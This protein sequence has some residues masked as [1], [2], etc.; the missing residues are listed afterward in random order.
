M[1]TFRAGLLLWAALAC[2]G[3]ESL[4]AALARYE[5]KRLEMAM[6]FRLVLHA[7]D[8]TTAE[9]AA[10]AAF[11]R[12]QQLNDIMSDY[13]PDSELSK[14][15]H[16]SGQGQAV[17]VSDDLWFVLERA[18]A[19]AERS[20]GAFDVTVGP[21]VNLWRR[22]R[23]QHKLPDPAR[24]ARAG[25]AVGYKHV[26]LDPERHTVELLAPN[27][28]LDLGGIAKGYAV[29]QA[30]K[31]LREQGIRQALIEAGGD[32]GVS[33]PPPG[34]TGWR[35]EL[36]S[37]DDTNAP[38]ARFL[39]LKNCAISTSG[40]LYQRLEING[41]RYSHIVDPHTGIG[42]TDHSVVNVIAP[43]GI[44]SD[45]LTKVV[46]VLGPKKGLEFIERTPGVVARTMRDIGGRIEVSESRGFA[47]YYERN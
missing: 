37:V 27:M 2:L 40:D 31:A 38:P 41:K 35:I 26:R 7:A 32:M 16:S 23:R 25:E 28:R 44:I 15:S 24:L 21:Y 8:Q 34:K 43:Q 39:L 20:G 17:H 19:L 18:Q 14:L 46:A 4:P 30:L 47:Q 11:Q 42:L 9:R 22:A 45:S 3:A 13:D 10:D 33:E 29:D 36:S 12:I 5:F 1:Q 6:E